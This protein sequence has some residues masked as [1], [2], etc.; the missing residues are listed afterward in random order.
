MAIFKQ[1]K[2]EK[3]EEGKAEAKTEVFVKVPYVLLQPRISE[4][5]GHLASVNK[6]I[7]N[8]RKGANKVEV[9]KAV[10]RAYKVSVIKVNVINTDGKI[11]N[12]GRHSGK[13]SNFKKAVVTLKK[14][15]KIEGLNQVV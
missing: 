6:Y 1:K 3:K 8:I 11:K 10:E 9:K 5:A 4:K 2:E 14:G 12:S 15:D 13:T 7:F